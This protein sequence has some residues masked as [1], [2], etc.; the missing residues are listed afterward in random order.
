MKK[1]FTEEQIIRFLKRLEGGEPVK[2]LC[3]EVGVVQQ[4]LYAWRRKY[5]GMDVS[6]AKKLRHLESE[7]E[8][9]KKIVANL[10]LDI[11]LLREVNS[12]NW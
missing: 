3:R 8:R 10:S 1:R 5:G 2:D 9:L 11:S 4:T 12:K 6:D 7:N